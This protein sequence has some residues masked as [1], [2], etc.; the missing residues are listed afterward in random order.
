VHLINIGEEERAEEVYNILKENGVEVLWDDRD[1]SPGQKFADADLIGIPFRVVI[2]PKTIEN[3]GVEVK[4][5][6]N[7]DAKVIAIDD[8]ISNVK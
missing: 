5:R 1:K 2:S 7:D 8:L 4:S 3:G 6:A